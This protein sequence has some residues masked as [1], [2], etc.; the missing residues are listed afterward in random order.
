MQIPPFG[1]PLYDLIKEGCRPKNS[2]YL[3]IGKNAWQRGRSSAVM[4]PTRTLILPPDENPI[5]YDW[6]VIQCDILIFDTGE[7]T[8]HY[9]DLLVFQLLKNNADVVRCIAPDFT[10]FG[11]YKKDL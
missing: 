10:Y 5:N 6:P 2:V 11:T 1:K 4:R 3:F 7:C 9:I 8:E